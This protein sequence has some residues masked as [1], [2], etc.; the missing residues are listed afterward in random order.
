MSARTTPEAFQAACDAWYAAQEEY[1]QCLA[2][3]RARHPLL[4]AGEGRSAFKQVAAAEDR[5]TE[6]FRNVRSTMPTGFL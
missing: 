2:A 6:A 5:L 3:Y 1:L 4:I